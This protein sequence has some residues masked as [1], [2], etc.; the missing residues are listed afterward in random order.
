MPEITSKNFSENYSQIIDDLQRATFISLDCE[1]SGLV[2]NDYSFFDSPADRYNRIRKNV[3][4]YNVIQLGLSAFRY[5]AE[6]KEFNCTSYTFYLV[7]PVLYRPTSNIMCNIDSLKFLCKHKFDFNKLLYYG[8]SYLN[9][10]DEENVIK[11]IDEGSNFV[12]GYNEYYSKIS[13][14]QRGAKV[15][16]ELILPIDEE[17]ENYM[18]DILHLEIRKN[19]L[20]LW[21]YQDKSN[22]I[23]I[24]K[25]TMSEKEKLKTNN[26]EEI[27]IKKNVFDSILGF[28][29][30]MKKLEKLKKPIV[31][32][33]IFMDLIMIYKQFFGPLPK[34]YKKFKENI[35]K[36][37]PVVYDTKYCCN[38]LKTYVGKKDVWDKNCLSSLYEFFKHGRGTKMVMFMPCVVN[39]EDYTNMEFHEAGLDSYCTGFCFIKMAYMFSLWDENQKTFNNTSVPLSSS[40]L[41][42]GTKKMKNHINFSRGKTSCIILDSSDPPDI[43][44]VLLIVR[45]KNNIHLNV[46]GILNEITKYTAVDFKSLNNYKG[47]LAVR[48]KNKVRYILQQ[49]KDRQEFTVDVYNFWIHSYFGKIIVAVAVL[50]TSTVVTVAFQKVIRTIKS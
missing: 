3:E 8:I 1:F 41:F 45:A 14:W 49:F 2:V 18:T 16:S 25:I 6:N 4:H 19:F 42:Q 22:V 26:N 30:V 17:H 46:T 27:T 35:N 11:M 13:E 50:T 23:K 20:D 38:L 24:R 48:N 33:N 40:W 43:P 32:H 47:L 28:S 5:Y 39:H 31:G 7:P 44:L 21:T 10:K 12:D 34:S 37:F 15:G 36:V 29:K 9:Q